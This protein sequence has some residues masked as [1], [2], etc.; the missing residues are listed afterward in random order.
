MPSYHALVDEATVRLGSLFV[1][2]DGFFASSVDSPRVDEMLP[3]IDVS[4]PSLS[5]KGLYE[6]SAETPVGTL[7]VGLEVAQWLG[8]EYPTVVYH[9]GND[10]RPFSASRFTPNTFQSILV[11]HAD[12]FEANIVGLRAPF[13]DGSTREYARKMGDLANFV[14]MLATSVATV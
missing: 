5:G 14:A 4:V 7:S 3:E 11:E 6:L 9:H 2:D 13:H 1:G 8:T 12:Q 10:E